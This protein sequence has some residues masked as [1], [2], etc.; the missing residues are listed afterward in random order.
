MA[1]CRFC[2]L[3]VKEIDWKDTETLRK[4]L[5]AQGKIA[6]RQRHGLCARHQRKVA[7]AIKR[8]RN[9]ALLPYA[10]R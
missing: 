9:L 8:A 1:E 6:P 4:F 5:S 7:R 3:N 2:K 10:T